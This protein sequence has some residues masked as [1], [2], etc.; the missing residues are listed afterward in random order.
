M[1]QLTSILSVEE[2]KINAI[3]FSK[4]HKKDNYEIGEAQTFLNEFFAVFGI[5]RKKVAKFEVHPD[6]NDP[7]RMDLFWSKKLLVEMKSKGK[8]LDKAMD[9]ALNYYKDLPQDEEPRYLLA[10]DFQIWYL[11]DKK[12]NSDY[13]FPL[14]ELADN[15]GLF[16]FMTDRPKL[17]ET[18]PVNAKATEMMGL[19]YDALKA[20][21]YASSRQV[22]Y[23]LT[24]LV[25]CLFA[26]DSGIF[27]DR[28]QFQKYIEDNTKKD[29][30][31]LGLYLAALFDGL[32]TKREDKK[33]KLTNSFPHINGALFSKKIE[34]PDFNEKLR[35]LLIDAGKYDW[36]KVSPAIFGNLFQTVMDQDARRE[37]GAHYTSEENI[38]KVIKPLILDKLND[39]FNAIDEIPDDSRQ[40]KFL[41]FQNKLSN[42]TF[43]DPACGSGNFLTITYREIRRLE[44]RVIMKIYGYSGKRSDT[45]ELSKVD[46]HQFYGIEKDPF[47]S[48]IAEISLWMMDHLMNLELTTR[49]GYRFRRIPIKKQ[50]NIYCR[51][52]LE[53]NWEEEILASSKC[54]YI[55]GNPPYGG[56]KVLNDEQRE[57][58]KKLANLGKSGGT[59][60]YICGWLIK[61]G[62]Y[63][64]NDTPIGFVTTNSIT[65]GEQVG[66]LWPILLDE[67]DLNINFAYDS[68]KWESESR[69]KAAVYVAILGLS[70]KNEKE[71]RLFHNTDNGIVEKFTS[72]ISPYLISGN[73]QLPIVKESSNP[74]NGLKKMKMGSKPI[75]GGHYIFTDLE[76]EEFLNKEPQAESF[77]KPYI[78]AKEFINGKSRWILKLH[79]Q[80]NKL[81]NLP[82]IKKRIAA[83][84]LFRLA[85]ISEG[86]RNLAQTPLRYHLNVFPTNPFLVFPRVSSER[87]E[88]VPI[89][90]LEPP[91]IPS[92]AIMIVEEATLGLFGILTS[93]MHMIW[94][95]T[96]GGRLKLDLRYSAG[97]V[98]NTFPVPDNFDS[99][100]PYAEKIL[101]ARKKYSDSTLADLYDPIT[102]PSDLKKAHQKLDKAVD[103]LYRKEPFESDYD[104]IEYLL[105][106]Y[107]NMITKN[108][109]LKL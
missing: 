92:D 45:D 59:L 17:V 97:M 102:M 33:L 9:E 55:L 106:R 105:L 4:E 78:N 107:K 71:K 16:N 29:G 19:I 101:D 50:P 27:T 60:D 84:K 62:Q 80:P 63:V 87:R 100:E 99:L 24:R 74:I 73:Q 18:H 3:K 56:S 68:F 6:E 28:G 30:S 72:Y 36:S 20:S 10:C 86:T 14:S 108:Q 12:D 54:S 81:R 15:I 26:D 82:E 79:I 70:K 39:E 32:N 83:V 41:E 77:F 69:G 13:Y 88:Y 90:Y 94:L 2:I 96:I 25:F 93:K 43:F 11:R 61:A 65:Q 47:S 52:A 57:Q 38:L 40:E 42:L 8:S 23:F 53:V 49:Y 37:L 91:I 1:N 104:R 109:T 5:D 98:Y 103:K 89:G 35:Q 46:V 58:I 44:L 66:Q 31:D 75:D 21:G 67:Y 22:E 48:K 76:K 34:F 85:S 7:D 95:R 51:D 64:Q